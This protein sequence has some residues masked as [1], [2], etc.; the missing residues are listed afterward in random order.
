MTIVRILLHRRSARLAAFISTSLL[1][2]DIAK[3]EQEGALP[4]V[5]QAMQKCVDDGQISGGVALV[6]HNGETA[7][8]DVFSDRAAAAARRDALPAGSTG[9]R[10]A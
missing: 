2:Q 6:S 7:K 10:T 1:I 4:G 3:S 8:N 9:R 5:T